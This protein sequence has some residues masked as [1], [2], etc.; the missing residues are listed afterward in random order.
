MYSEEEYIFQVYILSSSWGF[1]LYLC[2]FSPITWT[3]LYSAEC[4]VYS[5]GGLSVCFT[6]LALLI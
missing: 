6:M 5:A 4:L 1:E 3:R 2:S